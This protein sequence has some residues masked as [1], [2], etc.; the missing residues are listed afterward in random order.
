MMTLFL[1]AGFSKW[2][3]GLPLA[4]ELFDFN[5]EP[6]GPRESHRLDDV[7]EL[8]RLWD[9]SHLDGLAEQFIADALHSNKRVGSLVQWYIVRRLSEPFIW[10]EWHA[11]RWRRH[12]LMIDENRRFRLP[13]VEKA[14]E[15]LQHFSRTSLGGVITTNY[16]MLVEYAL[17]TKKF[18]YGI[19]NE[20]LEGRGTYPVS[21]PVALAGSIPLAKLH[22]SV[23]WDRYQK[24][25]EG[26]G[27][28]TGN[29]LIVPPTHDKKLPDPLMHAQRL[30]EDILRKSTQLIVF[31]FAFNQYDQD[32]LGLLQ[33]CGANLEAVL[34]VNKPSSAESQIEAAHRL[35]PRSYISFT[36]PPPDWIA[37]VVVWGPNFQRSPPSATSQPE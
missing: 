30:C 14:Q 31:G 9:S 26:R 4:S 37:D 2:A 1:G 29:V 12:S 16:D 10:K 33:S 11:G 23:S 32:I 22:G 19:L 3:A 28:V 15:F 17:G 21:R 5:F 7:R 6:W 24:H 13:E 34:L 27:G 8:K 35:W 18:N 36:A 25:T 20:E